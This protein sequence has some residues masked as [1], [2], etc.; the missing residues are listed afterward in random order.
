MRVGQAF[1]RTTL[2]GIAAAAALA[3]C[4]TNAGFGTPA[5]EPQPVGPGYPQS[6]NSPGPSPSGF[7]NPDFSQEPG[8]PEPSP[9]P[10]PNTLSI[11]GASLRLAYDGSAKDPVRANRLVELSFALQNTT[12]NSAKISTVGARSGAA[13]FSDMSVAV[14]AASNQTSPVETLVVKTPDDPQ[15]YKTILFS[16]L[17]SQKKLIGSANLDVPAFDVSFTSLDEKHPKGALS[18]DGAEVS[19]ISNGQGT[20]F[21]C[22][23]A[24]TNPSQIP[25]SL[26]EF[27]I[28]P[29]K[30]ASIKVAVPMVVPMRAASGFVSM[31][32][33]YDGKSLPNGSYTITAQQNGVTAAS[34]SAVLL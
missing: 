22:T 26:S 16:F 33:P 13:R 19:P 17:D 25:A 5:T 1:N 18:I 6:V 8:S 12:Q 32:V 11:V 28:K 27:D 31:I 3:A 20:Y 9:T 14:S 24:I 15:K 2:I 30:G 10:V 29:P 21:E 23:F 34:A 4:S 7:L